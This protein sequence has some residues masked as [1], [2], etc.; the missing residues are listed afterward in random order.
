MYKITFAKAILII[1]WFTT[2]CKH[3]AEPVYK[4]PA[5]LIE[6]RVKDLVGRMTLEEKI[7]QMVEAT[8]SDMKEDNLV[9]NCGILLRE[10]SQW[11]WSNRWIH[12]Y[13]KGICR[14]SEQDPGLPG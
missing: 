7:A 3:G 13:S 2:G 12:P 14:G 1:L 4:D 11:Y 5:A 8:C 10:I 9:K 6:E